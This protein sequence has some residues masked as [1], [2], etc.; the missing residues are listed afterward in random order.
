MA[1]LAVQTLPLALAARGFSYAGRTARVVLSG[2]GGGEWT[3]ACGAT[4]KAGAVPD[5]VLRMPVVDFCRR[6]A[7]RLPVD[8]LSF[9]TEGDA[10][11]GRALV[12]A[13]PAF[14]GL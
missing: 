4:E 13:A 9:D 10:D 6:F 14:A 1:E 11:F 2:P 8:D 3:I 7:D 12:E 5:V